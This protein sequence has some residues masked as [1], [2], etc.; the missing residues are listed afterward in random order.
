MSGKFTN[1][2][3]SFLKVVSNVKGY[4]EFPFDI[5]REET[6]IV[7]HSSTSTLILGSKN[8]SGSSYACGTCRV[9]STYDSHLRCVDLPKV[10]KWSLIWE[11]IEL[12][13]GLTPCSKKAKMKERRIE[14]YPSYSQFKLKLDTGILEYL[15]RFGADWQGSER[16]ERRGC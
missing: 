9:H 5:S 16:R 6:G 15:F 7:N 11:I 13:Y 4:E 10:H 8:S 12:R 14:A 1:V 2:T 3:D